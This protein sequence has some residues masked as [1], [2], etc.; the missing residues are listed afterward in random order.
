MYSS[1]LF[2]NENNVFKKLSKIVRILLSMSLNSI[3]VSSVSGPL[4][5][6][7]GLSREGEGKAWG[8]L[9]LQ[10]HAS[11]HCSLLWYTKGIVYQQNYYKI[12]AESLNST[13]LQ[14][15]VHVCIQVIELQEFACHIVMYGPKLFFEK[16]DVYI[17]KFDYAYFLRVT[18]LYHLTKFQM[19]VYSG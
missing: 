11:S 10:E 5:S 2:T 3:L 14:S 4:A 9:W 15:F 8:L 6:F 12:G 13:C 18:E 1:A 17:H 19:L 7:P 16:G